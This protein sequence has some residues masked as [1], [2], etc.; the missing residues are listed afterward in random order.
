MPKTRDR[1]TTLD[2]RGS[3]EFA[4]GLETQLCEASLSHSE[5][6]ETSKQEPRRLQ[7]A[8]VCAKASRSG[9]VCHVRCYRGE[10]L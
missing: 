5:H 7:K 2:V 1:N 8:L 6:L 10:C 4:I 9:G 3:A